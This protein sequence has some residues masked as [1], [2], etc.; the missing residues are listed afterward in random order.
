MLSRRSK[1]T[2]APGLAVPLREVGQRS[3]VLEVTGIRN[4]IEFPSRIFPAS[5][6]QDQ[7]VVPAAG[8]HSAGRLRIHYFGTSN[9]SA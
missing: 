9:F 6:E 8:M 3:T 1:A 7:A 2:S 4:N 5:G